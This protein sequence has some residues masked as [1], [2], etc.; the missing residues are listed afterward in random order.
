MSSLD[1]KTLKDFAQAII[2]ETGAGSNLRYGTVRSDATGTYVMIDGSSTYTPVLGNVDSRTGDRVTVDFINHQAVITSNISAPSS[3]YIASE[4]PIRVYTE[5]AK[6]NSQT[7]PPT[8]G[9]SEELP[10]R[11]P[12]EYIWSRMV[13]SFAS[14]ATSTDTP[15]M[16]TGQNGKDGKDAFVYGIKQPNCI[17][18]GPSSGAPVGS[19]CSAELYARE[20]TTN[21]NISVSTSDIT[22]PSGITVASITGNGS[23]SPVVVFVLTAPL[24]TSKT[25]TIKMYVNDIAYSSNMEFGVALNGDDGMPSYSVL[26]MS[27]N[28]TIFTERTDSTTINASIKYGALDLAIDLNGYV[29]KS[30][31]RIGRV[32]WRKSNASGYA[33][34][35]TIDVLAS[36]VLPYLLVQ[37]EFGDTAFSTI[38]SKNEIT[39]VFCSNI[40]NTA[41]YYQK[42]DVT[43]PPPQKPTTYPPSSSWA[44]TEPSVTE[45]EVS[46]KIIYYVEV[47]QY[48]DN[49]FTY[50]DVSEYTAFVSS[51][52]ALS[53]AIAALT[54]AN[55]ANTNSEQA[56]QDAYDALIA[57]TAYLKL[58]P[59]LQKIVIS[60]LGTS[61]WKTFAIDS[62]GCYIGEY[63]PTN[64][65]FD[66]YSDFDVHG[67]HLHPRKTGTVTDGWIS[68][69]F[70]DPNKSDHTTIDYYVAISNTSNY[71]C[72]Y[73]FSNQSYKVNTIRTEYSVVVSSPGTSVQAKKGSGY[74]KISGGEDS[75]GSMSE[76]A[77]VVPGFAIGT[78]MDTVAWGNTLPNLAR[79]YS[80]EFGQMTG[81]GIVCSDTYY[82]SGSQSFRLIDGPSMAFVGLKNNTHQSRWPEFWV[83]NAESIESSDSFGYTIRPKAVPLIGYRGLSNIE[84]TSSSSTVKDCSYSAYVKSSGSSGTI[85]HVRIPLAY[86]IVTSATIVV[87]M[88]PTEFYSSSSSSDSLTVNSI[89]GK[90]SPDC[91]NVVITLT[92]SYNSNFKAYTS[93]VG[94]FKSNL[95]FDIT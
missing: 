11:G 27:T 23:A 73:E 36:E 66:S 10:E 91:S 76:G 9:W 16:I 46:T 52:F 55:S 78:S 86:P 35:N 40:K 5:Y 26:L 72:L 17:F 89:S 85:I 64:N 24:T 87:D 29:S 88:A 21:K 25:A 31:T 60:K 45:S 3:G 68:M 71:K 43:S 63:D 75:R 56:K 41:R 32:R 57:A 47:V 65:T 1:S 28:G 59:V 62:V 51:K 61:S 67:V 4:Q 13:N 84:V 54:T 48:S 14:G 77:V 69:D 22:C 58:D 82:S 49:T 37:L 95:R 19:T 7:V 44:L 38:Y 53:K 50:S 12:N 6:N 42:L 18:N 80:R 90:V 39:L 2:G 33:Y 79:G 81:M 70:E 92:C 15:K 94:V 34:S 93:F 8:S 30:G 74:F 83:I 20:G